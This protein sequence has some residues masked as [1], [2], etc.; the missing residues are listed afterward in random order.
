MS[1]LIQKISRKNTKTGK[2]YKKS[3]VIIPQKHLKELNWEKGQNL[4]ITIK[5]NKLIIEKN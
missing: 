4:N 2:D 3:W 1:K 5:N